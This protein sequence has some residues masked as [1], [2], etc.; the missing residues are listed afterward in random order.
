MWYRDT[1][2]VDVVE[3]MLPVDLLKA[4]LPEIINLPKVQHLQ[5]NKTRY[6]CIF[7]NEKL[8][9]DNFISDSHKTLKKN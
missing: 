8:S 1:N 5:N 2:L 9:L 7:Y 3:K 4:G 6:A